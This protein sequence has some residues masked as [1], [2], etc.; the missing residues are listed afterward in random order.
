M[1]RSRQDLRKA[2]DNQQRALAL[3]LQGAS[4]AQIA[5]VLGYANRGGAHA[6]V[7]KALQERNSGSV[8][9]TEAFEV[10]AARLDMVIAAL[11]PA[12]R[13]GDEKAIG[14]YM[15]A[16]QRRTELAGMIASAAAP[17]ADE[18][19]QEARTPLDELRSR[20]AAR[21]ASA[22]RQGRAEV[23]D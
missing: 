4:Y 21:G 15:Q 19:T 1:A 10:E 16:A 2:A 11:T 14:R 20:R 9:T 23:A 18:V 3:H 13:A 22:A 5:D 12:V 8:G 17:A 6:A 7:K